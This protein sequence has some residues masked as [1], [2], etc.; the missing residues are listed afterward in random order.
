MEPP[1]PSFLGPTCE[2]SSVSRLF[3]Y[4]WTD[5]RYLA[6]AGRVFRSSQVL[7]MMM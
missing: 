5:G 2:V 3:M 6:L 4:V 7:C 1:S